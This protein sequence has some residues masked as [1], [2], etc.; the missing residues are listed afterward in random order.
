MINEFGYR[1]EAAPGQLSS[2][3]RAA[4]MFNNSRYTDYEFGGRRTGDYAGYFLSRPTICPVGPVPGQAARGIYGGV[5]AMYAPAEF[6]RVSQYYE[7]R[8][9]GSVFCPRDQETCCR[10]WSLATSSATIWSMRLCS[11]ANL[12]MWTARRSPQHILQRLHLVSGPAS[13]SGIPMTRRR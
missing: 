4:P 7:L 2:W 10:W 11:T 5:T 12:R 13:D 6:N 1:K 9:Y 3:A 8:F